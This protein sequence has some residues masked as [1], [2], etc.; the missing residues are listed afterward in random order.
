MTYELTD[1]ASLII[2]AIYLIMWGLG[3]IAGQQR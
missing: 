1:I 3:F 2:V